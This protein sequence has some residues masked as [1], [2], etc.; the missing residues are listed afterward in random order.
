M[1]KIT[2]VLRKA[3]DDAWKEAA[4]KPFLREMAK[5]TLSGDRFRY[6]MLQ[7]YLY[8]QDY[9]GI[10]EDT[11]SY[12]AKPELQE[13]L[14]QTI[15]ETRKETMRVHL[16][17]MKRIGVT[18]DEI[19]KAALAPE[20]SEYMEYMRTC[21]KERGFLAGLTAL[22]QC[23][24]V[25]AYIGREL[26]EKYAGDIGK[27]PYRSW[28]DSYT[29]QEYIDSNQNWIDVLDREAAYRDP[30]DEEIKALCRIF[31]KCAEYE[32]R[33]WDAL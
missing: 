18:D 11:R 10:L 1:E 2:D 19:G 17:N 16:P 26:T 8:L 20:F 9:I 3:A 21:L 24:W 23:S 5:G 13:F 31:V 12:T 14:D 22:L 27:S 30:D 15:Q 6:Y 4:A 33:I 7:D 25:Y 28:F 29:C 32:N